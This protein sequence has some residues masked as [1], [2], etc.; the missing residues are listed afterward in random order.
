VGWHEQIRVQPDIVE[1]LGSP[2]RMRLGD[3][4]GQAFDQ[5]LRL[6]PAPLRFTLRRGANALEPL[7]LDAAASALRRI[8]TRR[9]M[10]L[11]LPYESL[12]LGADVTAGRGKDLYPPELRELTHPDLKALMERFARADASARGSGAADWTSLEQRMNYI[13]H[14]FRS[15]QK[16]LELF[17]APLQA[18][19]LAAIDG[20]PEWGCARPDGASAD[21][22]GATNVA[23]QKRD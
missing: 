5:R 15:R 1:A 20:E 8:M 4:L 11:R 7:L 10:R 3:E 9:M 2:L 22:L 14:F 12:R 19:Q 6:L 18:D 16:S 17:T 13:I 21:K 23:R